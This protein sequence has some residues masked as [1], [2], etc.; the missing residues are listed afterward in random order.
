MKK[1][2]FITL[3]VLAALPAFSQPCYWVF[4][5]DK[6]GTTF[7]PYAYFDAKAIAR[8]QQCGADLYDIS[9]YPLNE[10]YVSQVCRIATEEVGS[11]RWLNAIGVT[12]TPDQIARIEAL[13]FV[14]RVQQIDAEGTLASHS[15]VMAEPSIPGGGLSDEFE[16]ANP[17]M[18]DQLVRQGGLLFREKGINGKGIRI[19]VFDTGFPV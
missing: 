16:G 9:N 4:L 5:K 6:Q 13:P 18:A 12:A 7:D 8:Y 11:S 19:A 17:Y 1:I 10:Q 14:L 3:V 2:F 15:E